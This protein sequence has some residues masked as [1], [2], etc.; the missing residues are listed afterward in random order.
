MMRHLAAA[1]AALLLPLAALADGHESAPD[2]KN[3]TVRRAHAIAMHGEPKYGPDFTHFEYANPSAPKGG[4]VKMSAAGTFDTFHPFILKGSSPVGIGR[5]FETLTENSADEPFTEYGL[6]AETIE[7][8]EDRSWVAYELRPEARWQDGVPVTVED[9]IW[10]YETIMTEGHP[11]YRS[12]YAA[13]A[14]PMKVGDRKVLFPFEGPPNPELPLIVGQFPILPKHYWEGRDFTAPTLEPPLGSGPYKVKQFDPGRSVVFE[15]DPN[16]WG[17]D[18]PLRKGH[19]NFQ[20]MQYDYYR[21]AS[22]QREAVRAGQVDFFRENNSKDW[23]TSYDIEPVRE[24][25]LIKRRIPNELPQGMQAFAFNTRR[26]IFADAK[27]REALAYAF[28]FEWTN[29]SLFYG[30]Y[31][32]CNS[33]FANTE[34]ANRELPAGEELAV[35]KEAQAEANG[36]VPERVFT[37]TYAAPA[38]DGSGNLRGNLR[39]ALRLLSEAGW[40]ASSGTLTHAESGRTMEFEILLVQSGFERIV[41]PFIEN[42]ERLGARVT[43]RT[44]DPAQYQNRLNA[45]DFDM[46]VASWGQSLSPGNEQRDMWHSESAA[47]EGSRNLAG[48]QNPAVDLLIERVI[49]A[50]SRESLVARTR[51]LDRALLWNHYVIPQWYISAYR[52]LYWDKFGMPEVQPKYAFGFDTWWVDAAR[53][54]SLNERKP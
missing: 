14:Q 34:L 44:I 45:F 18:L 54:A 43:V 16:Y 31:I 39:A 10:S 26:E 36:G 32:R 1:L 49:S 37:E 8:P 35:L 22:I 13:V 24:G 41:L 48:V 51:A 21:E 11:F 46:I 30:A 20:E 23:A 42:L 50:P 25:L 19:F 15:L 2:P 28:D 33:F 27:T 40:D 47:V 5:L 53:E 9:V 38:T 6:L 29:K 4:K 12:Y 52:V 7:W 17:R 3:Q